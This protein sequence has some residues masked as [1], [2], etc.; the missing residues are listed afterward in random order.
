MGK[1]RIVVTCPR[2]GVTVISNFAYE[3]VAG[4]NNKTILFAC[5]CGET[6]RVIYAGRHGDR[7]GDRRNTLPSSPAPDNNRAS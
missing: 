4:P 6:H 1:P 2:T 3:D 7:Y 5:A